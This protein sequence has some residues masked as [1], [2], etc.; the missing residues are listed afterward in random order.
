M[1]NLVKDNKILIADIIANLD[2]SAAQPYCDLSHLDDELNTGHSFSYFEEAGERLKQVVV[3]EWIC[4]DTP[5]GVYAYFLDGE[6]VAISTQQGRK[7]DI[8]WLW[9][10]KQAAINVRNL[11]LSL[12]DDEDLLPRLETI[13]P[14][15]RLPSY[16]LEM[17][18]LNDPE[19]KAEHFKRAFE[20]NAR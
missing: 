1:K 4:S 9:N 14:G 16:W 18:P 15:A 17:G 19:L 13:G 10:S 3:N 2:E 7:S 11:I 6:F 20:K 8:S 5:V 12:H